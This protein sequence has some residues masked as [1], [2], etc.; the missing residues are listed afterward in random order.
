MSSRPSSALPGW[1]RL[2][3][4]R[5]KESGVPTLSKHLPVTDLRVSGREGL[6][7]D[8]CIE[9]YLPILSPTVQGRASLLS[10]HRSK[11]LSLRRKVRCS[12]VSAQSKMLVRRGREGKA[13]D[14]TPDG[15]ESRRAR[16]K[17]QTIHFLCEECSCPIA[18]TRRANSATV[19]NAPMRPPGETGS[20]EVRN[21]LKTSLCELLSRRPA[22]KGL[23]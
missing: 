1:E 23:L 2:A 5:M 14:S 6:R 16:H 18:D 10:E 3:R 21:V 17:L 7:V 20:T 15:F 22:S 19:P 13:V 9:R 12:A 11:H 4:R 8:R